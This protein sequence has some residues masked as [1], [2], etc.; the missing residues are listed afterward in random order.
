[1]SD[2]LLD[3]SIRHTLQTAHGILPM[4]ISLRADKGSI[5]AITGPSGAGKTTLLR[6]IAGLVIPDF[7][8]IKFGPDVWQDTDHKIFLSPQLRPIGFVFQD[9]AL[10]PHLTVKENLHFALKKGD[11]TD[12]VD[13]LLASVEL[14]RLADRKPHQLSGGQQQR[15]AL[16]RALVRQPDLLLLDEPLSSLDHTM[17]L[18]LQEYLLKLQRQRGFT[19]LIVS[20]DLGEIFRMAHQVLVL[21]NGKILKQGSPSE[22][23][24]PENTN[25]EELTIYGEVL[26]C[27]QHND[28]LIVSALIQQSVRKLRLP[29]YWLSKMSPGQSFVLYSSMENPHIELIN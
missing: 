12:I 14:T 24:V 22:V 20:H 8:Y 23:Y 26:T 27:T 16:A 15:V 9:Y 7:G 18:R 1:M 13:E 6:Q 25:N 28:H 11:N 2:N 17:R 19:M 3:I 5:V 29:L 10:F 21:E 4:E